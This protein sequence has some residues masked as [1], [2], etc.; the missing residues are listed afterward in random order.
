MTHIH[1]PAALAFAA[2]CSLAQAATLDGPVQG[3]VVRVIDGDTVVVEAPTGISHVRIKGIDA[4][5]LYSKACGP[6]VRQ[7]A[8][9]ARDKLAELLPVGKRVSM[10]KINPDKYYG[11]SDAFVSVDGQD[12]SQAMLNTGLVRAYQGGKRAPWCAPAARKR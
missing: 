12:V 1:W 3:R 8:R 2:F 9:Q 7:Q 5:E 10:T 4:P 6:E 11:R